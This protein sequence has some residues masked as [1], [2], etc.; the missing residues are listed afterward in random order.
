MFLPA[1]SEREKS[2]L[3]NILTYGRYSFGQEVH[4][5][6]SHLGPYCAVIFTTI[7]VYSVTSLCVL[8][9]EDFFP[10]ILNHVD[11]ATTR[12]LI[13]LV[14]QLSMFAEETSLCDFYRIVFFGT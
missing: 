4:A 10:A 13:Q 3:E 11:I 12:I 8:V 2:L 1:S 9:K 14:R 6:A 7:V 5:H